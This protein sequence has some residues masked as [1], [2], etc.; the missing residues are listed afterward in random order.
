[1]K[2]KICGREAE[3]ECYLCL[4]SFCDS[5]F[6]LEEEV[7]VECGRSEGCGCEKCNPT[8]DDED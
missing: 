5:H 7:C 2:C 4:G 6:D 1:M 8:I 3:N